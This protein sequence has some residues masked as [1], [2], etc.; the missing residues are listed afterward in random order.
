MLFVLPHSDAMK[1]AM[2]RE[3]LSRTVLVAGLGAAVAATGLMYLPALLSD[4]FE[5]GP[6]SASSPAGRA[7]IAAQAGAPAALPDLTAL[8]ADREKW[9]SDHED[10][11]ASWAV[12]GAAYTERAARLGDAASYPRAERALRRSLDV[13]SAASGNL[14]AQLGL[15]ALANAR[16]EWK[17]ARTW[18]EK[19]RTANPERWSTYPVLIDAYNGIGDY[20]SAQKAMDT[21]EKLHH[22]ATVSA[23]ASQVHRNHGWRE[24]AWA[25]GEDAVARAAAVPEKAAALARLGDL[26]WERGEPE[27]A[28]AEYGVALRLAPDHG[29]ALA[30]RARALAAL[31]RTD[32]A[33][34]DYR[35]VLEKLPLPEYVLEA[36][37][38]YESIGLDGDAR[39][40]YER[41]RTTAWRNGANG[42]VVLGL[43]EADHG[44]PAAAVRRLKAEWARGHGSMHVAD[45]LGWA[46]YRA[47]QPQEA[48]PYAKRATDEGMRSALFAYHRGVIEREVEQ[49]GPARRHLKEA[50]RINPYFSPLLAPR[51]REAVAAL[52]D[53]PDDLP[54][55][56]RPAPKP[57][58]SKLSGATVAAGSPSTRGS[59]GG[60]GSGG[61]SGSGGAGGAAS[62]GKVPGAEPATPQRSPKAP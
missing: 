11:D 7:M 51:A 30:G 18:A 25:D 23:R 38:L 42:L 14:D 37:E 4:L 49:Y 40:T 54:E 45:A 35:T 52:G 13:R 32:E 39:A 33:V 8:I 21:L 61:R 48:L 9:L 3:N 24:D 55:E 20:K 43:Y 41:L 12:L 29:P 1:R 53:P 46:L 56:L 17:T 15:G 36:G 34:R 31:G 58:A 5:D 26:A 44:D 57:S 22:G 27:E 10:D 60:S 19:V 28:L 62:G 2:K 6:P 47:G 50:M 16:G 59:G